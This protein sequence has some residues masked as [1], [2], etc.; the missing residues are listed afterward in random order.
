M[1]RTLPEALRAPITDLAS[2]QG[3]IKALQAADLSFH[4]EDSPETIINLRSEDAD[5]RIFADADCP[6]IRERVASLYAQDWG[7]YDCPIGYLLAVECEAGTLDYWTVG[8]HHEYSNGQ[9]A[10]VVK[11]GQGEDRRRAI[12]KC[13]TGFMVARRDMETY[14]ENSWTDDFEERELFPSVEEAMAEAGG[15]WS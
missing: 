15:L 7:L 13:S 14:A 10:E 2:A 1:P 12:L 9:I 11:V 8:E 4:F 3:W 5:P 6:L